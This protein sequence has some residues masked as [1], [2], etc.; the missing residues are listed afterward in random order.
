MATAKK[1]ALPRVVA[2]RCNV[3]P[4]YSGGVTLARK[5]AQARVR[6]MKKKGLNPTVRTRKESGRVS[7][8]EIL[9]PKAEH[10][11]AMDL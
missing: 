7:C 1:K 4:S 11:R 8:L 9:V 6:Q 3:P 5:D 10:R 2:W